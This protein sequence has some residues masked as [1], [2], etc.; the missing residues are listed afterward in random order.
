MRS[1]TE[2]EPVPASYILHDDDSMAVLHSMHL[3][4]YEILEASAI[5][6]HLMHPDDVV[7]VQVASSQLTFK[8]VPPPTRPD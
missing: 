3:E 5:P 4:G 6:Q 1:W 8:G 2:L 7:V